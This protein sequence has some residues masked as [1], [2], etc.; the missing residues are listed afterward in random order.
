MFTD[1]VG[2]SRH[3]AENE[4][5]ALQMLDEH[6]NLVF[7]L[8]EKYEGSIVKSIGDALL[9]DFSSARQA[10]EC[11]LAIQKV[12]NHRNSRSEQELLLRI[13]IH[14]GD[15]WYTETDVFGDG[16]NVA[17]RLE[18]LAVPGG[19][20]VSGDVYRQVSNKLS[21][22]MHALGVRNLKNISN[23]VETYEL[24]TGCEKRS[25]QNSPNTGSNTVPDTG[26]TKNEND[27][28]K[29]KILEL[30]DMG[31]TKA[32]GSGKTTVKPAG[33]SVGSE[34]GEA[35]AGAGSSAGSEGAGG[36]GRASAQA[37]IDDPG[38]RVKTKLMTAA[39]KF[40]DKAIQEWEKQPQEK[41]NKI[42]EGIK[43]E[44]SSEISSELAAELDL[45]LDLGDSKKKDSV[46]DAA[47][48]V[49]FGLA[50]IIGTGFAFFSGGSWFWLIG[51]GLI[52]VPSFTKGLS[53]LFRRRDTPERRHTDGT[54][55]S[56]QGSVLDQKARE[57]AA[58]NCARENRGRIT[59]LQLAGSSELSIDESREILEYLASN[60]YARLN[61]DENG[62][63]FYEFHEF[64]ERLPE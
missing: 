62:L 8:V 2:Y 22:P 11:A 9:V 34:G 15:I 61:V 59:V 44:I 13:G 1:V 55:P 21:V 56:A 16:V 38:L 14:L 6:N 28:L 25:T 45:D 27:E 37:A 52:G 57:K 26:Q 12:L 51:L 23:P 64:I 47:G 58:L 60:E 5:T 40:M 10:C 48:E 63:L 53:K 42:I 3:M 20:V 30:A 46:S 32:F 39:D 36:A 54:K 50:V 17:S 43:A 49:G 35:E 29:Q 31:L 4:V 19:I 7:P 18:A 41:K 24:E 33:E